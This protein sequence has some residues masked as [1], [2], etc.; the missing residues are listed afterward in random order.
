VKLRVSK[1]GFT[2]MEQRLKL[3]AGKTTRVPAN[4]EREP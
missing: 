2:P 1:S 3:T 4:L